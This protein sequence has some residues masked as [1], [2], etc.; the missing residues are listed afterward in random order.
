MAISTDAIVEFFGTQDTVSSSTSSVA[1]GAY[2]A[3][4]DTSEW[5]NDD[6][7]PRA[8]AVL[9]CTFST[10]PDA[11]SDVELY[12]RLTDIQSTNDQ[13]V[14]T[15][16][17]PWVYLGS[18]PLKDVTTAQYIPLEIVLPNT[19]TSQG[20][21]FYIKNNGGQTMSSGWDLYITPK[22]FGPHA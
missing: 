2:S 4:A 1:D 12:A 19:K 15:D 20:Y 13:L 5:T 3:D 9:D 11:N 21:D 10:A 16:N 22:T 14:P 6:D 8:S 18:F 7:A 17:S